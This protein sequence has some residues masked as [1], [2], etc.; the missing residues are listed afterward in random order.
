MNLCE[1]YA[2]LCVT[3]QIQDKPRQKDIG[4]RTQKVDLVRATDS[5]V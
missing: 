1:G 5:L 2:W 4:F 3:E